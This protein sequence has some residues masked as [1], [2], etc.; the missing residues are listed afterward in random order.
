MNSSFVM[1]ET[2]ELQIVRYLSDQMSPK[3]LQAFEKLLKVDSDLNNLV[4]NYRTA[5]KAAKDEGLRRDLNTIH[6]RK[7]FPE[8]FSVAANSFKNKRRH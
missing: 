1:I 8:I 5:I 3:E 7:P 6:K 4:E 2:K